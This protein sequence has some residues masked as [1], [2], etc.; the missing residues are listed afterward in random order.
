MIEF[1]LWTTPNGHKVT[2]FLE[3]TGLRY[4]IVPVN[5]GKGEQFAPSFL[6]I[7]SNNRIPFSRSLRRRTSSMRLLSG[8]H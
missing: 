4:R 1:Y 7:A 8:C 5:I 3:E 2:M 6:R